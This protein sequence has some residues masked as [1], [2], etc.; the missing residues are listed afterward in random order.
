MNNYGFFKGTRYYGKIIVISLSE[1]EK[2]IFTQTVR[3]LSDK[4]NCSAVVLEPQ[5]QEFSIDP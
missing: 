2:Q 3:W 5:Q 4:F 1:N